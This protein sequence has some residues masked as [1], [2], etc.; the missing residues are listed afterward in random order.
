[1][2]VQ[3]DNLSE[4]YQFCIRSGLIKEKTADIELIDSLQSVALMGLDFIKR[5]SKKNAKGSK[6]KK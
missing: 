1:M 5:K 3:V 4:T 6:A 2:N